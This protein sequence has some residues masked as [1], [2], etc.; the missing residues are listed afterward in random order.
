[1]KMKIKIG[2]RALFSMLLGLLLVTSPV[3][4]QT[5]SAIV[6][7]VSDGTGAVLPGTSLTLESSALVGGPQSAISNAQGGY[8]F[9]DLPPGT[10]SLSVSLTGFRGLK[11]TG[12]R[13]QFGTTLT[14]DAALEVGSAESVTV[15]GR[16]PLVDVTTAQSTTKIDSDLLLGLALVVNK[17]S[18]VELLELT[19]GIKDHSAYGGSRDA[20]ELLLDGAPTTVPDR[21]GANAVVIASNWL[22]E[23]QVVSLGGSAE[24]GEFTGTAANFVVRNGTNDFHGLAE[25]TLSRDSWVG[26]NTSGLPANLQAS[27]KPLEIVSQWDTTLQAGGPLK[28]DKLFFFA[29][30]QYL[31]TETIQPGAPAPQKQTWPRYLGKLSWAASPKVKAEGTVTYSNSS[32]TGGGAPGSTGDTSNDTLQ[33]NTIWAGRVTWAPDRNSL[34]ELRTGGLSYNQDITPAAPRSKD[35]PAPRR[36][37]V[38]GISSGNAV[39]FRRQEGERLSFG[40]SLSHRFEGGGGR[41]HA[42]KI[43]LDR[44][45]STF[46]EDSGFPGG[47]SFVDRAG[48]P[49][50]VTLWAG[51]TIRPTANRTT[52]YVQDAWKATSRL[53]VQAGLRASF[54]RG[55]TPST[56]VIFKTNPVSPRLGLAW[57]VGADHKTVVRTHWGRFHEGLATTLFQ[58]MDTDSQTP[59]ITARVLGPNNF[60]ETNRVTPATNFGL[61]P[62]VRQAYVE[63]FLIG[64]ERQVGSGLS[65]KADLIHRSWRDTFAFIDTGSVYAPIQRTD[66][67]PDGRAGTADDGGALTVFNLQNPGNSFQFLTNPDDAKRSYKAAQLTVQRRMSKGWQVLTSYTRSRARGKAN[68]IQGDN[69]A[70]SGS[71]TGQG[72]VFADPNAAI[73]ADGRNTLDFPNQFTL[74]SSYHTDWLGG[75]DVSASYRYATGGAWSRSVTVTGLRQGNASVRVAPKGSEESAAAEQLDLRGQKSFKLSGATRVNIFVDCFNVTNKGFVDQA[76]YTEASGGTFGLPRQWSPP[77]IF[78][79]AARLSF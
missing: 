34:F 30:L 35:G 14:I 66:P 19:P 39:Q 53:T 76:R 7:V 54:N 44:E 15:E 65:V 64:I 69:V 77:R 25:Y 68:N 47:M 33:P 71:S 2:A 70:L 62:D 21:Q 49:D 32:V 5:R 45:H 74:R 41:G 63:Q 4:A 75:F 58:F 36:D 60:Q 11:R 31:K 9:V 3:E 1:M 48:V 67:G 57:D 16:T 56:G 51:N 18:S 29:G 46:V 78:Q 61:D 73:N 55:E 79:A 26:S 38:T 10:Y 40:A 8:R 43:G 28:K 59:R 52:L 42:V 37:V 13:L 20:N 12:L 6:G 24:Y 50:T 72:G 22:E 23:I 17:R 27:F